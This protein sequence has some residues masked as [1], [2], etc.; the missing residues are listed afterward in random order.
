MSDEFEHPPQVT[1]R[2][3]EAHFHD[4][5]LE[6]PEGYTRAGIAFQNGAARLY[7]A[8]AGLPS[9]YWTGSGWQRVFGV[10]HG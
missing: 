9:C 10:V 6:L 8:G 7:I 4:Q 3:A 1:L 2:A 5:A